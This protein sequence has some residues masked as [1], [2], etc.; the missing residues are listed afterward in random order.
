M[1]DEA[2][3]RLLHLKHEQQPVES[4]TDILWAT[5]PDLVTSVVLGSRNASGTH[6][7]PI[8][9]SSNPI[10]LAEGFVA[11]REEGQWRTGG[12]F[13]RRNI[14]HAAERSRGI[15][16]TIRHA[17]DAAMGIASLRAIRSDHTCALPIEV[18]HASE[19]SASA[20]G[21][22][23]N[24]GDASVH[25]ISGLNVS[26]VGNACERGDRVC[27]TAELEAEHF[28][29]S[30]GRIKPL[31]LLQSSFDIVLLMD[32]DVL[33]FSTPST[34]F[35]H[36]ALL[37]AG[38]LAFPNHKLV[39]PQQSAI[40]PFDLGWGSAKQSQRSHTIK[41]LVERERKRRQPDVCGNNSI[42]AGVQSDALT[43]GWAP[44]AHLASSPL[45]KG[46][47]C[48]HQDSAVLVV[49]KGRSARWLL[50][51]QRWAVSSEAWDSAAIP[52][53]SYDDKEVY[54]MAAEAAEQPYEFSPFCAARIGNPQLR[55]KRIGLELV[56]SEGG[57]DGR[58]LGGTNMIAHYDP[59]HTGAS[60]AAVL[61]AG[62]K[63]PYP[64][65][66]YAQEM[67]FSPP[68]LMES[69]AR[70]NCPEVHPSSGAIPIAPR[71]HMRYLTSAQVATLAH[72]SP[73][74]S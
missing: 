70:E 25:V 14:P 31:V 22:I 47:S 28:R 41:R 52:R 20:I 49:D 17:P 74:R 44:S 34:L 33:F 58:E 56:I 57:T 73:E 48:H 11:H 13:L 23:L 67:A 72:P 71:R 37:F 2:F 6:S 59:M 21:I 4:D 30:A 51:L 9:Q 32:A 62:L 29:M 10:R 64:T 46:S 43:P 18:W 69:S 36:S 65:S 35:S 60:E 50:T 12:R 5:G 66:S 15:A 39:H 27:T 54:W 40:C 53:F 61:W 7:V 8:A 1:L 38:V 24:L 26:G 55:V 3:R 45:W 19:L 63:T 68:T 42:S 16:M